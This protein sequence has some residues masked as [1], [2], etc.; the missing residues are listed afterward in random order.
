[1]LICLPIPEA[2]HKKTAGFSFKVSCPDAQHNDFS[3]A[4]NGDAEQK[5][6]LAVAKQQHGLCTLP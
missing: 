3:Q 6:K 2:T 5:W 4:L 1:M